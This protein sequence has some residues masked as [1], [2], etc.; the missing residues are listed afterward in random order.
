VTK[1]GTAQHNT[2][3]NALGT[4]SQGFTHFLRNVRFAIWPCRYAG[5]AKTETS[6]FHIDHVDF[7][8]DPMMKSRN[9]VGRGGEHE[10]ALETTEDAASTS[11]IRS[12]RGRPLMDRFAGH[13]R[14]REHA[15]TTTRNRM[16]MMISFASAKCGS[17]SPVSEVTCTAVTRSRVHGQAGVKVG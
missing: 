1:G 7:R 3:S 17:R 11:Q 2:M 15:V 13:K 10:P 9:G 6:F 8:V 4:V 14:T 5:F 16:A 12:R